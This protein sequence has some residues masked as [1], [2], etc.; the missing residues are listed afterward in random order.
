MKLFHNDDFPNRLRAALFARKVSPDELAQR[1]GC[2]PVRVAS[3]LE[4]AIH[5]SAPDVRKISGVL[6]VSPAFLLGF[7]GNVDAEFRGGPDDPPVVW[8][9]RQLD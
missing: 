8:S 2:R 7:T 5:A 1:I 9:T 3:W 4:S 6:D